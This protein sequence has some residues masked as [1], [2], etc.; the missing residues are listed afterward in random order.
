MEAFE[1]S[2]DNLDSFLRM[3][4]EDLSD[5]LRRLYYRGIGVTD[6]DGTAIGAMVCEL[7]N[8]DDELSKGSRICFL[9][10]ANR[11]VFDSLHDFYRNNTVEE[12]EVHESA[13]E[14]DAEEMAKSLADVGFTCE[15]KE[16]ESIVLTLDQ[17]SQSKLAAAKKVPSYVRSIDSLSILQFRDTV[18][19]IL[20]RGHNGILE[21]MAYLSMKWFDV[22]VSS[23]IV[24]DD[25]VTGLF[26]V[27]RTPS[28]VMI[29]VLFYAFGLDSRK[30][31][32]YMLEYS[33]K[34]AI[35]SYPPDTP[36]MI[37]RRNSTIRALTDHL[38]PGCSG[39]Q[40]YYGNR[41]EK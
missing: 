32:L 21:D 30:N 29:P 7:T 4:G 39:D 20:F 10:S 9:E 12:D 3:L 37:M 38:F 22:Q 25:L 6:E 2:E 8:V 27:R 17:L 18:K 19:Q 14:L 35:A 26:L 31:L 11:E 1:I 13:Y 28:G 33:V 24:S 5:D 36:V 23:C 41:K 15:K 34:K 40:I 16:S